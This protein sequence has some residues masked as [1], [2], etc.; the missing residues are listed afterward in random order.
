MEKVMKRRAKRP[1]VRRKT[2]TRVVIGPERPTRGLAPVFY[3][4]K[5]S[6]GGGL[7]IEIGWAFADL[8]SGEVHSEAFLV[9][10]PPN[11][12]LGPVWDPDVEK[13]HKVTKQD[14]Y[15]HGRTPNVIADRMNKGLRGRQL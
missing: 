9:K 1:S 2:V 10:P 3:D 6:C 11:W 15:A 7:P 8:A 12:D 13:L 4:C 14:L 5:A